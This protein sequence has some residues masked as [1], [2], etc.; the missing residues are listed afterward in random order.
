MMSPITEMHRGRE[1]TSAL[2]FSLLKRIFLSLTVLLLTP[3]L[4]NCNWDFSFEAAFFTSFLSDFL[5]FWLSLMDRIPLSVGGDGS[6]PSLSK[7][8]S[9]DLNI[10]AAE[11]EPGDRS[12]IE[13]ALDQLELAKIKEQK[14]LLAE[15][16][17]P[18]IES[19][20]A[21]LVRRK[22]HRNLDELP[23]PSEMVEIIIDR[24]GSK[25][26]Y[27]ANK[28]NVPRANL[29]HLRAWLTRAQHSAEQDGKGNMSIKN[30]I[31]SI[32]EGYFK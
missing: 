16:I 2:F 8:P 11:E 29:R 20:K 27:N 19:E 3:I 9:F 7:K 13:R 24:F 26:A 1:R 31:S 14:D 10:S 22:W 17:S 25:A 6:G 15:Q 18:L 12:E 28:P 4:L 30:H 23:S 21:R 5:D 32:I